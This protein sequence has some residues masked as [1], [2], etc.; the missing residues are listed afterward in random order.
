MHGMLRDTSATLTELRERCPAYPSVT[1][2]I[3]ACFTNIDRHMADYLVWSQMQSG[4]DMHE[5][6]AHLG[7]QEESLMRIESVFFRG[8]SVTLGFVTLVDATGHLHPI[9][10]GVCDSFERFNEMLQL[11]FK[12]N[13]IEARLQRRYMEQGEYNLCIDGDKQVT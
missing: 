2:D 5:V 9:P 3:A 1:Q 7:R 8:Q 11:L 4:D 13:S 12:H 6:L 10:M